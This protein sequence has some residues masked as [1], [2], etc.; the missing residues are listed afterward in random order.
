MFLATTYTGVVSES[1][2]MRP[3]WFD[4]SEEGIPYKSMWIDDE[5]WLPWIMNDRYFR[6]EFLLRGHDLL[7]KH[8][9]TQVDASELQQDL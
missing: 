4:V 9:I 6:A 3:A 7:L 8:A 1:D 2:E 5:V